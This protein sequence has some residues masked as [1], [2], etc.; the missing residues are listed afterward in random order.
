MSS[1]AMLL[2]LTTVRPCHH[3]RC[4]S[5]GRDGMPSHFLL[6]AQACTLWLKAI[7][8]GCE[9]KAYMTFRR[10]RLPE[11]DGE[12]GCPKCSCLDH[13][14][15]STRRRFKCRLCDRGLHADAPR[16]CLGRCRPDACLA[17][18][19]LSGAERRLIP[20][21]RIGAARRRIGV[22]DRHG[23]GPSWPPASRPRKSPWAR[24]GALPLVAP[25]SDGCAASVRL[26]G[27]GGLRRPR[28]VGRPIARP[29]P[30][31]W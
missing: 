21:W 30:R 19:P 29:G 22:S 15:I 28:S 8:K 12:P 25:V 16:V 6:S 7:Y 11:T 14:D 13:H 31:T 26:R 10:L 4:I 20:F 1:Y 27:G 18:S 24:K 9:D 5:T 2:P 23:T 17:A 3:R